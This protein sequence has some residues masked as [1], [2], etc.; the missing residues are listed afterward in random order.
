MWCPGG[1]G[2]SH[3]NPAFEPT[4]DTI[5][6]GNEGNGYEEIKKKGDDPMYSTLSDE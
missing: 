6:N 5:D 2:D 4:Y 3:N 1:H